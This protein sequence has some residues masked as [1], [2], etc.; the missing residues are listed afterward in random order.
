[1]FVRKLTMFVKINNVREYQK[2]SHVYVYF[3][4]HFLQPPGIG[5][6]YLARA[7][8]GE[9]DGVTYFRVSATDL[10]SKW[11]GDGER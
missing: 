1:M 8:A 6:T 3:N 2:F 4:F 10:A 9:A 11:L 7:A 5:K